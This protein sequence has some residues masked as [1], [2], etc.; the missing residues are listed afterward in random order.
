[1]LSSTA[2]PAAPRSQVLPVLALTYNAFAWGLSWWPF[3]YLQ[4]QGLH[5]LWATCACYGLAVL[6]IWRW[7]P[8]AWQQLW[9][10]PA[11]WVVMLA[12]GL[13]NASF[14]W[15]VTVGDVVR[16][17]LLFYLMPLWAVV[18][19]RLLLGE[20]LAALDVLR[21][22]L[23]LC[24]AGVVLWPAQGGW[25]LPQA[26][27]EWLGLAGGFAFAVNNVMLRR[28]ARRPQ[29]GRAL[30]MFAGSV[31]AAGL[32][33][34]LLG[35]AG[36]VPAPAVPGAAGTALVVALG[37]VFLSSNLALQYGAARLPASVT[38]VVMLTEVAFAAASSVWLG[39][40]VLARTTWLGGAL[41]LVAA[42]LS[43]LPRRSF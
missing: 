16:V 8:A 38:A 42:A 10:A 35:A 7:R 31:A 34:T 9:S 23:A 11:L 21:V 43:A 18:L 25:P 33:G 28:E 30:A 15:A 26:L 32:L 12:S 3:R 2:S 27:H 4:A 13:T 36:Q 20:R 22:A 41:I 6:L 1:M 19:A 40:E 17:V 39:G 14:N 5:P 37:L 29:E 24:G